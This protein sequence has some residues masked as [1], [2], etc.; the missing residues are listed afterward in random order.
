MADR[1]KL[2]L[3]VS[4]NLDS[5]DSFLAKMKQAEDQMNRLKEL[6]RDDGIQ[7]LLGGLFGASLGGGGFG[8]AGGAIGGFLG[9]SIGGVIGAAVGKAVGAISDAIVATTKGIG[10][11]VLD[12]GK[13][14]VDA[15]AYRQSSV[16]TLSKFTGS[17][18]SAKKEFDYVTRI[19]DKTSFG[20]KDIG[21]L[22]TRL[23]LQNFNSKQVDNLRA[24]ALD[25]ASLH[26][27]NPKVLDDYANAIGKIKG[28]GKFTGEVEQLDLIEKFLPGGADDLRIQI[29]K[30]LGLHGKN[31]SI[32]DQVAKL[33]KGGKVDSN[34][35]INAIN[36]LIAGK[37]SAIAGGYSKEFSQ[38]SISGAI[39]N[40]QDAF[41]N[42]LLRIDWDNSP[43]LKA[44][45][46]FL[47][48]VSDVL[49]SKEF[50]FLI[51]DLAETVF[52]GFDRISKDD[53]VSWFKKLTDIIIDLKPVIKETWDSIIGII[54]DAKSGGLISALIESF[55]KLSVV[56]VQ[57]MVAAL[58]DA[59]AP[60]SGK[61]KLTEAMDKYYR[62]EGQKAEVNAEYAQRQ[63]DIAEQ[64]KIV[65]DA[66]KR[67]DKNI[68]KGPVTIIKIGKV[69]ARGKGKNVVKEINGAAETARLAAGR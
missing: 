40:V 7:S 36:E 32:K 24:R 59:L 3:D 30:Q 61:S 29:G 14:V 69:D 47:M 60:N 20:T 44:F 10:S 4:G 51:K 57:F 49:G 68:E 12:F 11:L 50:N 34:T 6:G 58:A 62:E 9:G 39:S 33:V 1:L 37:T 5:L 22:T 17:E 54:R 42:S 43:G 48:N 31:Q 16:L 2:K 27:A 13:R 35:A 66:E 63:K 65:E 46:S 38:K 41:S 19:A 53:I 52:G 23:F 15:A 28:K 25:I 64:K 67:V 8:K 45:R 56:V 26:G 21:D 55:A 18:A